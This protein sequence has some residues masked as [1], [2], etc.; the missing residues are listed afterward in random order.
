MIKT[1]KNIAW[2]ILKNLLGDRV[3]RNS[4]FTFMVDDHYR[5]EI[6][7]PF[8]QDK[9]EIMLCVELYCDNGPA[10]Y[11]IEGIPADDIWRVTDGLDAIVYN[12]ESKIVTNADRELQESDGFLDLSFDEFLSHLS[13]VTNRY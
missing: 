7:V 11:S 9:E 4:D 6:N 5:L 8:R 1:N 10:I 12:L 3:K 13:R 2:E